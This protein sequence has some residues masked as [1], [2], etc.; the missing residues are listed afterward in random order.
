MV[1]LRGVHIHEMDANSA[2]SAMAH[3]G[4]HLESSAGFGFLHAEMNFDLGSDSQLFF[5]QNAHANRTQVR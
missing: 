3:D 5:A 1:A 4:A 2:S